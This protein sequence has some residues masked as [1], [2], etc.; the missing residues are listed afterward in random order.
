[1]RNKGVRFPSRREPG[2]DSDDPSGTYVTPGE[3]SVIGV[4]N[5]AKDSTSVAV[6][7]DPR[8]NITA[9]DL[10]A[11]NQMIQEYYTEVDMAQRAFKALQDVRKDVKMIEAMMVN[12]P[13]STQTKLKEKTKSLMKKIGEL[14]VKF[15][16]AE[17][18]K[19]YTNDV[20]LGQYLSGTSSYLNS[21]LGEP[22]ANAKNMLAFTKSE[23]AKIVEE[24]NTFL[25]VDWTDYKSTMSDINWPLFKSIDSLK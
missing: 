23:V 19:G 4:F 25:S 5:N 24:V 16:E 21:S 1:M 22:G 17:D 6:R 11:R 15:M 7:I 3:Y 2:K 13:D 18:V 10:E 9:A 12:A 20:N 14:E 8:L